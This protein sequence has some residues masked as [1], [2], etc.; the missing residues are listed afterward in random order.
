MA[1]IC[2]DHAAHVIP[3]VVAYTGSQGLSFVQFV[4]HFSHNEQPLDLCACGLFKAIYDKERKSKA[5]KGDTRKMY[6]ALLAFYKAAIIPLVRWNFKRAGF[7]LDIEN[8]RNPVQIAPIR[9][10]DRT[11]VPTF[12]WLTRSFPLA[13]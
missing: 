9:F 10:L 12:K 5:M 7:L 13:I 2:D 8:L 11:G 3:R 1:L 4:S 6:C